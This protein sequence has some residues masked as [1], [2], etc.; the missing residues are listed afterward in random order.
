M[1][2]TATTLLAADTTS[3]SHVLKS[4]QSDLNADATKIAAVPNE[5]AQFLQDIAEVIPAADLVVGGAMLFLIILMHATG[6]R[7]VTSHVAR[8]TLQAL[9]Y[10][11]LW[12]ADLLMGGTVFTLLCLHIAEISVWSVALVYGGLV[13]DWHTAGFFAG[14]CFTALGYGTFVLPKGWGML[15]PIIAMS[16]LFTFGWSGSVLVDL[17][18]RCQK[19]KDA[20]ILAKS[21]ENDAG[22]NPPAATVPTS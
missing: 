14:N 11:S 2:A 10:P 1:P 21:R 17:I 6:V 5:V 12:R 4:L 13:S 9:S 22:T 15:A 20:A 18:G 16:G 3:G 8:R 19:I 7:T